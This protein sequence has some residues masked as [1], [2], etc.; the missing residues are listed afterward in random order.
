MVIHVVPS[1]SIHEVHS[2][3]CSR[4]RWPPRPANCERQLVVRLVASTGCRPLVTCCINT[5]ETADLRQPT[6]EEATTDLFG[7]SRQVD[8]TPARADGHL[9]SSARLQLAS[10][11]TTSTIFHFGKAKCY[12][13]F[14]IFAA[15]NFSSIVTDFP[16]LRDLRRLALHVFPALPIPP[17]RHARWLGL[18][19]T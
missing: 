15:S 18:A 6:T 12:F 10:P 11:P 5:D 17:P 4:S 13:Q 14:N 8:T 16:C 9:D 3:C 1:P 19:N 2:C 7:V